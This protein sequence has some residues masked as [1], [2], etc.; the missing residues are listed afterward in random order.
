MDYPQHPSLGRAGHWVPK[1]MEVYECETCL[2]GKQRRAWWHEEASCVLEE[3]HLPILHNS[4]GGKHRV[5][6]KTIKTKTTAKEEG[7]K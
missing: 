5:L 4:V 1:T 6:S 2:N 3:I 7:T